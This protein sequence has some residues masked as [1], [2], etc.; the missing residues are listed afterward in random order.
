M[1][2]IDGKK[3]P[4]EVYHGLKA[5]ALNGESNGLE[6]DLPFCNYVDALKF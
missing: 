5:K 3:T 4:E 1:K 6:F 2:P